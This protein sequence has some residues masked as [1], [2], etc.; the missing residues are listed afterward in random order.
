MTAQ[1]HAVDLAEI[2]LL[3]QAMKMGCPD[4]LGQWLALGVDVNLPRLTA[5]HLPFAYFPHG[6]GLMTHAIGDGSELRVEL[7]RMLLDAGLKIDLHVTQSGYTPLMRSIAASARPAGDL[8]MPE[9]ILA[10][11]ADVNAQTDHGWTAAH[12]AAKCGDI[13]MLDV[14]L[15][16]G[17]SLEATTINDETLF[18]SAICHA[19][20]CHWLA[21]HVPG[22][23]NARN[24]DRATALA[25]AISRGE[26]QTIQALM[27]AGADPYANSAGA[28]N[29][30]DLSR[31]Y[32]RVEI[33]AWMESFEAAKE[34]RDAIRNISRN[35]VWP[36][37]P[38]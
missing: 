10:A 15:K 22:L 2:R 25:A 19:P 12:S 17:A 36:G 31:Y 3:E 1:R 20:A 4:L 8:R 13:E 35:T 29:A 26:L 11:G 14:L 18:H 32:K 30:F 24:S 28:I 7:V 38:S 34:A 33:T 27:A 16:R 5:S 21:K 6:D 23:L 9:M 37:D